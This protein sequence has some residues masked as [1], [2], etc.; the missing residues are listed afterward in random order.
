V[1]YNIY[2]DDAGTHYDA[3][4]AWVS[5][6]YSVVSGQWN[7]TDVFSY[8]GN[9]TNTHAAAIGT[10]IA[11]DGTT[12]VV[13]YGSTESGQRHW[14]VR[15]RGFQPRLQIAFV[16]RSVTVSWPAAYTNSTL[17]WTDSMGASQL[18]KTFTGVVDV[19]NGQNTVTFDVAAGARLFRLK[20]TADPSPYALTKNSP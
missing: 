12:F 18:W 16:G 7:T 11:R 9:P 4:W 5:R 2:T 15:K 13:G 17:E 1:F 14:V 3:N 10:A 8:S 6:Q 19:V 20:S